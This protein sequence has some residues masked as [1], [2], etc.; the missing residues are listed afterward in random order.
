MSQFAESELVGIELRDYP[1]RD[2]NTASLSAYEKTDD[3][4]EAGTS[5]KNGFDRILRT[6]SA[7]SIYETLRTLLQD[8]VRERGMKVAEFRPRLEVLPVKLAK[9]AIKTKGKIIFID[10][11]DVIAVEAKGNH[12]VL[13]RQS[14]WYLLRQSISIMEA[15]L[16]PYGFLR[17]HRS[18]LVN[19]SWVEEIQPSTTGDCLLRLSGNKQYPVSRTY[20]KNLK[21]LAQAWI[22]TDS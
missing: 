17:I 3:A 14:D 2:G 6:R 15:K 16:K 22:G 20:K 9:I 13:R 4:Q 19:S 1:R 12:V 7:E 8:G 11:A 10:P 18:V 5:E 21:L